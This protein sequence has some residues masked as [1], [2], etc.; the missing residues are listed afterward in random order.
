MANTTFKASVTTTTSRPQTSTSNLKNVYYYS[1]YGKTSQK[2]QN[3]TSFSY[4]YKYS[5]TTS[6]SNELPTTKST[7]LSPEKLYHRYEDVYNYKEPSVYTSPKPVYEVEKY[8]DNSK[9]IYDEKS[10][11]KY[12]E[13]SEEPNEED[14]EDKFKNK[15]RI[16]NAL[17][18]GIGS[19]VNQ[20]LRSNLSSD[21]FID[22]QVNQT[23]L[24]RQ[25]KWLTPGIIGLIIGLIPIT[26]II[27]SFIPAFI[28]VPVI[29]TSAF[30]RRRRNVIEDTE[31]VQYEDT[32]LFLSSMVLD[33]ISKYGIS[34][35]GESECFSQMFCTFVAKG[36]NSDN[37][38]I[39]T[40][41]FYLIDWFVF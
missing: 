19:G 24:V 7:T 1:P 23:I 16:K 8:S 21:P 30:S 25:G 40:I 31:Y 17:F 37:N 20:F 5:T 15:L 10:S 32:L 14:F 27:A 29:S 4:N 9:V 18:H 26:T 36:R 12:S 6:I 39:E 13:Y 41:I 3:K 11:V 28:A 33:M 35:I 22:P 38:T 2:K 34:S